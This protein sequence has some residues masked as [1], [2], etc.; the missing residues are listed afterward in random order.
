VGEESSDEPDPAE[1]RRIEESLRASEELYARIFH[2]V[3]TPICVS[4]GRTG[5]LVMVNEAFIQASG[6]WRA[7]LI[8]RSTT[9]LGLWSNPA[10]REAIGLQLVQNPSVRGL[11][12][13]F[14]TKSGEERKVYASFD[15]IHVRGEPMV[16][17][18]ILDP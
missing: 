10:D 4:S 11:L 12:V 14:C 13:R 5:L 3:P 1:R 9:D 16:V 17:T 6:F 7:E 8:G 2:A 18:T 15:V